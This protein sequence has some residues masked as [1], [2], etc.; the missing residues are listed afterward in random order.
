MYKKYSRKIQASASNFCPNMS[1]LQIVFSSFLAWAMQKRDK[2]YHSTLRTID[3]EF[4]QIA[5]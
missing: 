2:K 5:W 4:E 3:I 1:L